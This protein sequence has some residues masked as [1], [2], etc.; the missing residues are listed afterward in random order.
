MF[1]VFSL[2]DLSFQIFSAFD[3]Q[4]AA[5]CSGSAPDL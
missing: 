4:K 2:K 5:F 3:T 1:F